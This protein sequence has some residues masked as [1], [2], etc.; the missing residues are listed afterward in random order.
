[1][2]EF[3]HFHNFQCLHAALY[4]TS[5]MGLL[6]LKHRE[7]D[8]NAKNKAGLTPLHQFVTRGDLGK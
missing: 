6:H 5:L 1:M 7:L 2:S 4:K 8:L 3:I